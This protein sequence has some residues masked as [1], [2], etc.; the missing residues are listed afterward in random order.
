ME[1]QAKKPRQNPTQKPMDN[2]IHLIQRRKLKR[3]VKRVRKTSRMVR[4][5]LDVPSRHYDVVKE[6]ANLLQCTPE[7][8][9]QR[10]FN[11]AL[12]GNTLGHVVE[13]MLGEKYHDVFNNNHNLDLS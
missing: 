5:S 10:A 4:I 13:T 2:R 11:H 9:L 1:A 8:V 6:V 12:K 3:L 7:T